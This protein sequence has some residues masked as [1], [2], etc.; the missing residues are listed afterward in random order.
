M[1]ETPVSWRT[2]DNGAGGAATV[3]GDVDWGKLEIDTGTEGRSRVYDFSNSNARLYTLTSNRYGTGQ[4][5]ASLE[6]RGDTAIFLQDDATP[7]W[8]VYVGPIIR[9]WRYV[10]TREIR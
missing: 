5:T 7:T 10:Q 9:N 8:E 2:W 3:T 1:G 6:I 4:G